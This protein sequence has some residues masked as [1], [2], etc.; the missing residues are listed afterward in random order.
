MGVHLRVA[1][2]NKHVDIDSI[3]DRKDCE[4]LFTESL[5]NAS[6]TI[7]GV[8]SRESNAE[9]VQSDLDVMKLVNNDKDQV[10]VEVK[11]RNQQRKVCK[12]GSVRL[13]SL[14]LTVTM[15]ELLFRLGLSFIGRFQ[16]ND[17]HERSP[18]IDWW[19]VI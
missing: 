8:A 12:V 10:R 6:T 16:S 17:N 4:V 18:R 13:P 9:S 2:Q 7:N 15:I 19:V 14:S 11:K 1:T 5:L 3:D